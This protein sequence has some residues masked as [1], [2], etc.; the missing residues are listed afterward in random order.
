MVEG[1]NPPT[2]PLGKRGG[3]TSAEYNNLVSSINATRAVA[4]ECFTT[5]NG[6][7]TE[8]GLK[9]EVAL[10]RQTVEQILPTLQELA[11]LPLLVQRLGTA[12][13]ELQRH[14]C[15]YADQITALLESQ[16]NVPVPPSID[17]EKVEKIVQRDA[18]S[19]KEVKE[20]LFW[21]LLLLFVI[22][23]GALLVLHGINPAAP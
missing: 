2:R 14:P 13:T 11:K 6:K 19:W 4:N 18:V 7:D 15:P 3:I 20:R 5:L 9:G 16:H 1:M 17:E 21:P 12:V 8:L 22:A 23:I 10:V